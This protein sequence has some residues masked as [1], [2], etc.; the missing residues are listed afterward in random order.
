VATGHFLPRYR[1][2]GITTVKVAKF[3]SYDRR[4]THSKEM[5]T[6][7]LRG[8]FLFKPSFWQGH[9]VGDKVYP[10]APMHVD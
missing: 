7:E 1:E 2:E 8:V 9:L 6:P 5:T 4:V 3:G 10:L